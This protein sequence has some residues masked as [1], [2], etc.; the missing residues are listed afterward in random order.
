M[1]EQDSQQEP[2]MEEILA[3]IR[4]IISE[5]DEEGEDNPPAEAEPAVEEAFDVE[6][7]EDDVVELTQVF[8]D[9][10]STTDIADE[11]A[12]APEPEPEPEPIPEPEPEPEAEPEPEPE[13]EVEDDLVLV[14][15]T[16]PEP[17]PE[18][19][20]AV[21]EDETLLSEAAAGA[22]AASFGALAQEIAIS[23][24]TSRTL[25]GLV[26]DMLRPLL[27]NWLDE[28][29]PPMVEDLIREEIQRVAKRR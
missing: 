26:E 3:S 24:G 5:D 20:A 28:N 29:L 7:E 23:S 10:G 14:D 1:A 6:P 16:E 17:E 27:K 21:A 25:E 18:P 8:N 11:E 15:Q 22:A 13:P 2:T 19:V 12:F 4:R 9:D